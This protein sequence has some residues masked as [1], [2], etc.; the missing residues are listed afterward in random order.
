MRTNHPVLSSRSKAEQNE[1]NQVFVPRIS[2]SA[3]EVSFHIL[4]GLFF[5]SLA[6]LQRH[7]WKSFKKKGNSFSSQGGGHSSGVG[8]PSPGA[9]EASPHSSAGQFWWWCIF[10]DQCEVAWK[11]T[12]P[13]IAL[14]PA[15]KTTVQTL[16]S[17]NF[18]K[19]IDPGACAFQV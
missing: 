19:G 4:W 11:P 7:R 18:I 8:S 17:E 10:C 15:V 16:C 9:A 14:W 12:V 6:L 3:S 1:N 5:L 2:Q 13:W